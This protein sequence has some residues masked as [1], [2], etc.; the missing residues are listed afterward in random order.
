VHFLARRKIP[1][2]TYAQVEQI[3]VIRS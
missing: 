3:K 2:V 1:Q